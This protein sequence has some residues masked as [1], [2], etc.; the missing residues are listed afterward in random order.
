[1]TPTSEHLAAERALRDLLPGAG[2]PPPDEV[3]YE[4]GEVLLLWHETK[5]AVVIE[6]GGTGEPAAEEAG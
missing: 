5:L 6:L 2:L 3:R 1:M 4:P